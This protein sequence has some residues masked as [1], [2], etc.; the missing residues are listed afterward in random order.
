MI[1]N[2]GK[3]RYELGFARYSLRDY[4]RA[5]AHREIDGL[6]PDASIISSNAEQIVI[7]SSADDTPKKLDRLT[8]FSWYRSIDGEEHI[9]TT[10][11]RMESNG[12]RSRN[13]RYFMHSLHEYKGRF[14]PQLGKSLLNIIGANRGD[15]VLDPFCGSGTLLLEAALA[16][17]TSIGIDANPIGQLIASAKISS[18][19]VNERTL[20]EMKEKMA[21]DRIFCRSNN[22]LKR[23]CAQKKD[24][25][26]LS[27]WFPQ[28]NLDVLLHIERQIEESF[29]GDGRI[30]LKAVLS[31]IIKRFSY[32]AYGEQRIRRRKDTPP[33]N[34]HEFFYDY[35]CTH[36][37][38]IIDSRQDLLVKDTAPARAFLG[39]ARGIPIATNAI[40]FVITSPPYATA[41]PYIDADRLSLFILGITNR[42]NFS[43]VNKRMIGDREISMRDRTWWES[44]II[45]SGDL[46][47]PSEIVSKLKEIYRRN[48][49]GA[50]GFRRKNT[51]ALLYR[52]FSDMGKSL[53]EINRILKPGGKAAFV[54]GDNFTIADGKYISIPTSR[55]INQ[56]A[57]RSG[58]DLVETIPMEVQSA[59][60]IYSKNAIKQETITILRK[61]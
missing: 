2:I 56:I 14:Y 25:E 51:A 40:D 1:P 15:I 59:Y 21:E 44:K 22:T 38:K 33:E 34:V 37:E 23:R 28:E 52:Y 47:L 46:D 27:R 3:F 31:A 16:G 35:L 60:N 39:D 24:L 10:Q 54:V 11:Q 8:F 53:N 32:Q 17:V 43:H 48:K 18:L 20:C 42:N 4:E 49:K 6:L 41:L 50:V 26:Y 19:R 30:I 57:E 45:S 12:G 9:D 36:I 29:L 58:F 55:F 5:L 7:E 13:I 61:A